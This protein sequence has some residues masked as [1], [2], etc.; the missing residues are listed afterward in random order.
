MWKLP[1]I[2]TLSVYSSL[3]LAADISG[4]WKQIDD[5][6]G[7][8]KALIQIRQEKDGR[9][10]GKIV[11]ITPR[12]GYVPRET[13]VDCPEPYRNKPILGLDIIHNLEPLGNN[14][15]GNGKI[16]DPL[17]GKIYSV[18]GRLLS[19]GRLLQLRGYLGVSMLGRTQVWIREN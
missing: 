1:L 5:K 11:K 16:I 15:Y 9:Y 13:C 14:S 6:T 3:S 19:N 10:I 2:L 7:S 8:A 12:P 18:K 4:T 17:T